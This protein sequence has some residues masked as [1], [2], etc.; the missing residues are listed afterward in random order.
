MITNF[1]SSVDSIF[2]SGVETNLGK[3]PKIISYKNNKVK[4]SI[5]NNL[6]QLFE[7]TNNFNLVI[8]NSDNRVIWF[9]N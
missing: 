8:R 2:I 9:I 3:K 5:N 6:D 4:Y 1:S 7:L